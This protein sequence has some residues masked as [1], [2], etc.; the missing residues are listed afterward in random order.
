MNK[1]LS[2]TTI[3]I[4]FIYNTLLLLYIYIINPIRYSNNKFLY[5][6]LNN[7]Y[8]YTFYIIIIINIAIYT[9]FITPYIT[10]IIL[11]LAFLFIYNSKSKIIE[12]NDRFNIPPKI[13]K[14]NLFKKIIHYLFV[15]QQISFLILLVYQKKYT[16]SLL[17]LMTTN[18]FINSIILYKYITYTP[19][20]YNLPLSWTFN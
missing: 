20:K 13:I 7:I 2:D 15:A 1:Y 16:K 9:H 18:I 10:I 4:A 6:S 14:K 8:Q 5:L 17:I 3:K 11:I 12:K 19:C